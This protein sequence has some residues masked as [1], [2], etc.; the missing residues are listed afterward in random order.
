LQINKPQTIALSIMLAAGQPLLIA[1]V[2]L[3]IFDLPP[4]TTD[5]PKG[6]PAISGKIISISRDFDT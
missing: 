3:R 4:G 5:A 1:P 2:D 6:L